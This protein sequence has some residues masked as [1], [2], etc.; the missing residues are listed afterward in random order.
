M[1]SNISRRKSIVGLAQRPDTA[2]LP[3]CSILEILSFPTVFMMFFDSIEASFGQ[4]GLYSLMMIGKSC[5]SSSVVILLR[6]FVIYCLEVASIIGI[7]LRVNGRKVSS[8][9]KS[10]LG[11]SPGNENVV[12]CQGAENL[13]GKM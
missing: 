6:S 1:I 7:I 8:H 9:D 5:P 3:I 4:S 12:T 13:I 11:M 10:R 2:V